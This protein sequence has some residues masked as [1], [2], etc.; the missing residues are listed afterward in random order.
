MLCADRMGQ[1]VALQEK[2]ADQL[3]ANVRVLEGRITEAKAKKETLK[4]G[5]V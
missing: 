4:V 3:Q 5:P 2:A 1:Q